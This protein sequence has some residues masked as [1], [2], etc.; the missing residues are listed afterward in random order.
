VSDHFPRP[1][2]AFPPKIYAFRVLEHAPLD[3]FPDDRIGGHECLRNWLSWLNRNTNTSSPHVYKAIT[4]K[5]EPEGARTKTN[6]EALAENARK[7]KRRQKDYT[8]ARKN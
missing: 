7:V 8:S 6:N 5:L 4:C 2:F 3:L 1:F